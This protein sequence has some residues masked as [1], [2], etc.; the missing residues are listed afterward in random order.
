MI[1]SAKENSMESDPLQV[2]QD[3]VKSGANPTSDEA[4][5]CRKFVLKGDYTTDLKDWRSGNRRV[6]WFTAWK[7][8]GLLVEFPVEQAD[9]IRK[10]LTLRFGVS[11]DKDVW[12]GPDGASIRVVAQQ[13]QKTILVVI[14]T[15]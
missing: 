5:N 10:D 14:L 4:N 6:F 8:S 7:L 12:R 11:A 3:I 1:W 2:C 15:R 9:A 13:D